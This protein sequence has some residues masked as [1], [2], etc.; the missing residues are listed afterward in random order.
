MKPKN[1]G[2]DDVDGARVW[3]TQ[4]KNKAAFGVT[5]LVQLKWKLFWKPSSIFCTYY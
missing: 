2:T 4:V 5:V 1:G 3:I